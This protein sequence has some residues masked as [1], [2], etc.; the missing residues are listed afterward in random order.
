M[1]WCGDPDGTGRAE[2]APSALPRTGGAKPAARGGAV[3]QTGRGRA[4]P[5]PLGRA[6][7]APWGGKKKIS[8]SS[9]NATNL[10]KHVLDEKKKH[11]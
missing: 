4:Q 11:E 3:T 2:P 10:Q 8:Q 9:Q 7:P 6:K 5:P 1:G